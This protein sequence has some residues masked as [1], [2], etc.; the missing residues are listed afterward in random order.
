MTSGFWD[1]VDQLALQIT[2]LLLPLLDLVENHL[3]ARKLQSLRMFYQDLHT[4][5]AEAGYLSIG[6]RWSRNIFRFSQPFPGE[7][8]DND[9]EHVDD[10][11][12]K[13][14]EAAAKRADSAAERKWKLERAERPVMGQAGAKKA[15][16]R[17]PSRMGKVQVILWPKLQ[18][19]AATGKVNPMMGV[20]NG[21]NLITILKSQVVYY[22]GLAG[23]ADDEEQDGDYLNLD[24]WVSLI[25]RRRT[26]KRWFLALGWAAS[27]L[28]LWLLL[29][30]LGSYIPIVSKFQ[31]TITREIAKIY[32]SFIAPV[33]SPVASYAV[34]VTKACWGFGCSAWK[35][36]ARQW[37]S[38]L[39]SVWKGKKQGPLKVVSSRLGWGAIKNKAKGMTSWFSR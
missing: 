18:R 3:P 15:V 6:I 4:I 12:Y 33:W 27:I 2:T 20:A 7:V 16:W 39:S 26:V 38:T 32:R 1:A 31:H 30:V 10:T 11:I 21:E 17:R 9:Q 8:W 36:I 35:W 24:E 28:A 5:V 19:F 22:H 25:K 29:A 23:P 34:N 14:S 37:P 13:A